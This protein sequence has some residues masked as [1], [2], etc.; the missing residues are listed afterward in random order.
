MPMFKV[1]LGN[2]DPRT[3][4]ETL[5]PYFAPFGEAVDEIIVALDEEGKP[6]GFAIVLFRDPQLGQLAIETLTGKRIN[7]REVQINEAVKKGKRTRE[8]GAAPRTSPLGPRAAPRG[9]LGPA[10]AVAP[11]GPVVRV[12]VVDPGSDVRLAAPAVQ[13]D[14]TATRD[15]PVRRAMPAPARPAAP[16]RA[17]RP[18]PDRS[19]PARRRL[20]PDRW[21]RA[22][23]GLVHSAARP[24][25]PVRARSGQGPTV[26]P[27]PAQRAVRARSVRAPS[28]RVPSARR[29]RPAPPGSLLQP[30]RPRPGRARARRERRAPRARPTR[31]TARAR[32]RRRRHAPARSRR[33]RR[34]ATPRPESQ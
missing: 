20:D 30:R 13:A 33:S 6:R 21:A 7:G 9:G 19:A 11:A 34:T 5:K 15:A 25:A 27:P 10:A 18:A 26:A 28:A 17:L 12:A 2:L 31:P 22:R 24:R 4:V 1:Y 29:L 32:R 16:A 8:A 23:S 3:T 14:S